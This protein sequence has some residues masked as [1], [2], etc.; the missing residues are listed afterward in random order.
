MQLTKTKLA[1]LL[2]V[3]LIAPLALARARTCEALTVSGDELW[4]VNERGDARRILQDVRGV[5]TPRFSP[6][7]ERVAY[8]R[9][10]SFGQGDVVSTI[11][12]ASIE[13]EVLREIPVPLT[14]GINAVLDLGWLS[15][16]RLWTEGHVT[17]SSGLYHEWPIGSA[18]PER[19][20]W[21]ALFSPSP[22]GRSVAYLA[23]VPHG[24][25]ESFRS[26]IVMIDDRQVYPAKGDDRPH[27]VIGAI[28][29][30]GTDRLA[31]AES[32]NGEATLVVIDAR[33]R[34]I[35]RQSTIGSNGEVRGIET[36]LDGTIAI[37]REGRLLPIDERGK[38]R[39]D[40]GASK[41]FPP[42][43]VSSGTKR[44]MTTASSDAVMADDVRCHD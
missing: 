40:D 35:L 21:G 28:R 3:L 29:W 11:V 15:N 38:I 4:M 41:L 22:D 13:G 39:D 2:A 14:A 19:E 26:A 44:L 36:A 17:P 12:V 16:D 24:A 9:N 43:F 32:T 31:F 33:T 37:E 25:P 5:D 1:L 10:F 23:H 7:G 30:I 27:R 34:R 42:R 20:R 6:G 18:R 8:M